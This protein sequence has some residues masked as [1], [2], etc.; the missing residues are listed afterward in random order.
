PGA[1]PDQPGAGAAD[2]PPSAPGPSSS[3][4]QPLSR[5]NTRG[6]GS[7]PEAGAR[8]GLS[9]LSGSPR[10]PE[11]VHGS[12]ETVERPA[13]E[14]M[15]IRAT[16][17]DYM[18][19]AEPATRHP[20]LDAHPRTF[21]SHGSQDIPAIQSV[22][23]PNAV[24]MATHMALIMQ[25]HH[26]PGAIGLLAGNIQLAAQAGR[27]GV[28]GGQLGAGL[29]PEHTNGSPQFGKGN[30]LTDRL[31]AGHAAE[32]VVRAPRGRYCGPYNPYNPDAC[33]LPHNELSQRWALAFATHASLSSFTPK[34]R[35]L[36]TPASLPL[37]VNFMPPDL[38]SSYN[39]F[40]YQLQTPDSV[41]EVSS[42][43]P[44]DYGE[45]A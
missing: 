15:A 33:P 5:P 36:C 3:H 35:S 10:G 27:P 30:W 25:R 19:I 39:R 42:Q 26:V 45:F 21:R 32:P 28:A 18:L 16:P 8:Q 1:S 7:T 41:L 17:A 9:R 38:D 2:Q 12:I 31:L 23:S 4:E 44:E 22:Q 11:H 34:W 14:S 20:H 6:G 24:S 13:G 29:A 43:L 37:V 40:Q